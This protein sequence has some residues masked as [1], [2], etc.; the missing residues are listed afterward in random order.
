VFCAVLARSRFRFARFAA[1]Q[2]QITTLG[3]LAECF[4]VLGWARRSCW[5][6]TWPGGRWRK[7]RIRHTRAAIV[8]RVLGSPTRPRALALGLPDA[9]GGLRVAGVTLP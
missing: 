3:M 4:E 9:D 7:L 8:G 6:S 2:E 1:D 5:P